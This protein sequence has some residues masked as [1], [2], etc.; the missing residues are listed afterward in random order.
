MRR[1][2]I[3]ASLTR[4]A[5]LSS[6]IL[7][8]L[9]GT[10]AVGATTRTAHAAPLASHHL[11]DNNGR[12]LEHPEIHNLYMSR[13]WD[14]DNPA[15]LS[16]KAIDDF[17]NTL[18]T[19]GYFDAAQE[20]GVTNAS[21]TG[22]DGPDVL[23]PSPIADGETDFFLIGA[24]LSCEIQPIP[25]PI[26]LPF[27]TPVLTA[28]GVTPPDDNSLYVIYLP[29]GVQINDLAVKTCSGFAAYHVMTVIPAWHVD[30]V[31]GVPV[32]VHQSPQEVAFAV[33][34]AACAID[35]F[36]HQIS[37]DGLTSN[38]SHEIIEAATD[39]DIGLGWIEDS[40][41]VFTG[42]IL[43][44]GEAADI[45]EQGETDVGQLPVR[46][47]DGLL[48]APYWSNKQ[49]KC[50]P[51][52][53]EVILNEAGLPNTVP[54][55]ATFDGQTVN[56]PFRTFI[57]DGSTH[58]YSFPLLVNDPNPGIRYETKE[59]AATIDGTKDITVIAQYTTEFLLTVKTAPPAAATGNTSLTQST[60]ETSG[61]TIPLSADPL[62]AIDAANR[63]R[64]DHWSDDA[65]GTNPTTTIK[66]DGPKTATAN[67]VQQHRLVVNTSGLD[68]NST[69]IFNGTTILGTASAS[70]PLDTWVDDGPLT[71]SASA[72]VNGS[73]GTQYF[74]QGFTPPAPT[75]L[76]APFTT[77]A[78]YKTMQ[79][80]IADALAN[81]GI[82]GPGASGQANAFTQ[83][84]A[85]VQADMSGQH[86]AQALSDLQSFI[87]HVQAQSGKKVTTST[88]QTF[89][90]DALLVY[91]NALCLAASAGQ[92]TQ[93]TAAADYT[94]YSALVESLG[95]TVLPPC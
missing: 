60:W 75:T 51:I 3:L 68:A 9:L 8:V 61:S 93:A 2:F 37:F 21:F 28:T 30:T 76:T 16:S 58:S 94:F 81:G 7:A 47:L 90:L 91:H 54:Q 65:S 39:P 85:A 62:V 36:T 1:V 34:P 40:L 80:L 23:C 64:F 19:S 12:V 69:T 74:F 84:F 70:A 89:Q 59:P 95:G 33:V 82:S 88:A 77:T 5:V 86:Y 72:N 15:A 31:L 52:T 78:V 49:G 45:C 27:T 17:T 87:S 20:Y 73:N 22:S 4:H 10:A 38:A 24:W 71:L 29:V 42:D 32:G 35:P 48:V 83:Q 13:S 66:M 53:R 18:T 55:V 14:S 92:I 56:L 6:M 46:L 25:V 50:E 41:K 26:I 43:K 57:A 44:A 11:N 67:Y 63:Y 79:Q